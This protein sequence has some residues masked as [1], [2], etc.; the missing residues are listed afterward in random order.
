MCER[1]KLVTNNLHREKKQL[2]NEINVMKLRRFSKGSDELIS[3]HEFKPRA[4]VG[5]Y[6]KM[7]Y[8]SV[9]V[10]TIIIL[11]VKVM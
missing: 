1:A 11:V 3:F 8:I 6:L 4:R 5:A 7:I 10:I 9:I 2:Q